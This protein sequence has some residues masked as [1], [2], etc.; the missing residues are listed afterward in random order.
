MQIGKKIPI[1]IICFMSISFLTLKRILHTRLSSAESTINSTNI[2]AILLIKTSTINSIAIFRYT[3]TIYPKTHISHKSNSLP[4]NTDTKHPI[5]KF[6]EKY[7]LWWKQNK[8]SGLIGTILIGDVIP[9]GIS[10]IISY[11]LVSIHM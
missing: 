5:S 10:K 7:L 4:I 9:V 6:F 2:V 11:F 8:T 1:I 3:A